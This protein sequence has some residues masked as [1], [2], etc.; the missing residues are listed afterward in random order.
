MELCLFNQH[1]F[2]H[3]ESGTRR[4]TFSRP[5]AGPWTSF[6]QQMAIRQ[7]SLSP[8]QS[9]PFILSSRNETKSTPSKTFLRCYYVSSLYTPHF[10]N[11]WI[12]Y[13]R[14]RTSSVWPLQCTTQCYAHTH[15]MCSLPGSTPHFLRDMFQ[16]AH[17]LSSYHLLVSKPL[18]LAGNLIKFLKVIGVLHRL[19]TVSAHFSLLQFRY[20]W[21]RVS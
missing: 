17:T 1:H 8:N 2:T 12:L 10:R 14:R 16:R 18:V 6:F 19:W 13:A 3:S 5:Q 11:P 9:T 4:I 20:Q 7:G 15:R 21:F